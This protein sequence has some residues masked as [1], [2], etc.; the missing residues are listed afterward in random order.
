M[1]KPSSAE[2]LAS[3]SKYGHQL[4]FLYHKPIR[5]SPVAVHIHEGDHSHDSKNTME[6]LDHQ[7][8]DD[9]LEES[10]I[11]KLEKHEDPLVDGEQSREV[12]NQPLQ[13]GGM[14]EIAVTDSIRDDEDLAFFYSLLPSVRML[15]Q[16]QK[17]SFRLETLKALKNLIDSED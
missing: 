11:F 14:E 17:L 10:T 12:S 15:T 3:N 4:S 16:S 5:S 2:M 8:N 1:K 9:G 13:L 6:D 7:E